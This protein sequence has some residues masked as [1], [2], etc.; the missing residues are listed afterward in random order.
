MPR[1]QRSRGSR[2]A[3]P[4]R[5]SEVLDL[6]ARGLD[7]TRISRRLKLRTKT[8]R[9]H[10]SNVFTKPQ[11]ADRSQAVVRARQAGLGRTD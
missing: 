1:R 6:V 11:L 3:V 10:L 2:V 8:V 4:S 9:H 7:N 5:I